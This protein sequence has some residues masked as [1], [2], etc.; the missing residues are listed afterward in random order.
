M[1]RMREAF[2]HDAMLGMEPQADLQ[3]P[4]AAIT[5]ALCGHW[6]HDPPCPLA[7]H[8]TSAERVGDQVRVHTLFATEPGEED[9]VRV[10]ID[11]AP[12]SGRLQRQDGTIVE[13]QLRSS[14]RGAVAAAEEEPAARLVLG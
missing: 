1:G 8:R 2:A 3:A 13:W 9:T 7:P 12:A 11:S 14:G 4:G 10:L 6:E 5:A